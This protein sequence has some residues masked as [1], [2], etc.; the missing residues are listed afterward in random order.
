MKKK[1]SITVDEELLMRINKDE[2]GQSQTIESML[3]N[4]LYILNEIERLDI[5]EVVFK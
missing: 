5:S 2:K 4:Y 3:S 1:I